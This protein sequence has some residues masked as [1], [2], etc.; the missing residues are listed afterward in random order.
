MADSTPQLGLAAYLRADAPARERAILA[1]WMVASVM[2][3]ATGTAMSFTPKENP[4]QWPFQALFWSSLLYVSAVRWLLG[5]GWFHP[6]IVWA[7]AAVEISILG[8]ML[9]IAI[10]YGG[11]LYLVMATQHLCLG[12]L[13]VFT[14]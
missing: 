9:A 11:P 1:V 3:L 6:A 7:N 4:L 2:G 5:R 10:S 13:L 12:V 8:A 14:A